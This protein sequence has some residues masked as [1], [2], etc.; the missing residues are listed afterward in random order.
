MLKKKTGKYLAALA[1]CAAAAVIVVTGLLGRSAP[2]GE[3]RLTQRANG[4]FSAAAT[5]RYGK[6][7]SRVAVERDPT[8]YTLTFSE[9]KSLAGM[10]VIFQEEEVEVQYGALS[11][12]VDPESF[13][14]SAPVKL[15]AGAINAATADSGV[16]VELTGGVATITGE[17]D[18]GQF[19]L[20]LDEKSGNFLSLSIPESEFSMEFENFQFF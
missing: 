17:G 19:I 7:T 20:R 9:P 14:T 3:E 4:S 2:A 16:T 13:A 11:F 10:K 12:R 15:L 18:G 5:L 1:A 8:S 6:V